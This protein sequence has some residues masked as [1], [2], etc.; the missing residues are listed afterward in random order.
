MARREKARLKPWITD[1]IDLDIPKQVK[2]FRRLLFLENFPIQEF[3]NTSQY[4][5]D[6]KFLVIAPKGFGKTLLL[7]S[8]RIAIQNNAPNTLFIPRDSSLIDRPL[9]TPPIFSATDIERKSNDFQYWKTI[10]LTAICLSV[11]SNDDPSNLSAIDC[12]F[13][14]HLQKATTPR[15]AT[16]IFNQ[17]LHLPNSHY[18]QTW[19]ACA[20]SMVPLYRAIR[21]PVATFIDNIDDYFRPQ[22]PEPIENNA[23]YRNKSRQVWVMA[24]VGLAEAVR[25]LRD[26]NTQVKV[27]ATLRK[28][29]MQRAFEISYNTVQLL[30]ISVELQYNVHELREIFLKNI[31][32]MKDVQLSAPTEADPIARFVGPENVQVSHPYTGKKESFFDFLVRHSLGRPRDLMTIGAEIASLAI[33]RSIEQIRSAVFLGARKSVLNYFQDM[34]SFIPVPEIHDLSKLIRKNVLSDGDLVEISQEYVSVL[35]DRKLDTNG[36]PFCALYRLGLLGVLHRSDSSPAKQQFRHP[37]SLPMDQNEG[38][39]PKAKVYLVHP[40]LDDLISEARGGDYQMNFERANII[41]DNLP[42]TNYRSERYVI[43][44]DI[45]KYS[46][47]MLSPEYA[48]LY[49]I[50]F[51][52]WVLEA[53]GGL[54][55]HSIQSGDAITMIDG[56]P[57]ALIRAAQKLSQKLGEFSYFPRSLRFGASSGPIDFRSIGVGDNDPEPEGLALRSAARLEE[58]ASASA[59]LATDS[60]IRGAVSFGLDPAEFSAKTSDELGTIAFVDGKFLVRKN[61]TDPPIETNLWEIRL[62]EQTLS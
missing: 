59:I 39:L 25:E 22:L 55:Y 52:D 44:G 13:T 40:S 29:A 45:V 12:D 17:L 56:S 51:K 34:K 7:K 19:T 35:N 14:R 2:D 1:A 23:V 36:H 24:Q 27:F 37:D 47:V 11:I 21:R 49:P 10:W 30:G 54:L 48:K 3:L 16:D 28:E 58:I 18:M 43:K 42:W 61:D 50:L 41:G 57:V 6:T 26:L 60:F 9:G 33:P 62:R 46:E 5:R 53:C 38:V 4:D 32:L 8:K 20:T 31:L 15:T